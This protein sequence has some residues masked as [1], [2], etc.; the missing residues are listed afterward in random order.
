[1]LS[2]CLR[3]EMLCLILFQTYLGRALLSEFM[4][5]ATCFA[6]LSAFSLPV[7]P[8]WP[9]VHL[10][11]RLYLAVPNLFWRCFP[12]LSASAVRW[13]P[14]LVSSDFRASIAAWLS[15]LIA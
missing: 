5:L 13:C 12:I 14:G 4:P 10:I 6:A 7:I 1:L 3:A 11:V 8:T 9:A 15:R 2:I